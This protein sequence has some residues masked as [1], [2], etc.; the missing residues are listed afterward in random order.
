MQFKGIGEAK[1]ITIIAALELGRRRR[2]EETVEL[3]KI[4]SSKVIFD[5][6][7]PI[8]GE[9]PH[10]EFLKKM[11]AE[12]GPMSEP[13]WAKANVSQKRAS[14]FLSEGLRRLTNNAIRTLQEHLFRK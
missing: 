4:T 10:E 3:V 2:V 8:I 7:Q 1:A 11:S 5:V 14:T 6:M 13:T 12:V 9:M